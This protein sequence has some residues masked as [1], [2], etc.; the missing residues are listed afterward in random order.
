GFAGDLFDRHWGPIIQSNPQSHGRTKAS[1]PAAAV[2][3][4]ETRRGRPSP[5]APPPSLRR[6]GVR[7]G[8]PP[9]RPPLRLPRG[10]LLPGEERPPDRP[11]RP[12]NP[13]PR[14]RPAR[15]AREPRDL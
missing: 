13:A 6:T 2:P 1:E 4:R 12:R 14:Q 11:H 15:H 3:F 9:P 10:D 5:G 8:R 7:Q